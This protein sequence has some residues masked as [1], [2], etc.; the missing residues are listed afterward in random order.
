[1]SQHTTVQFRGEPVEIVYFD[2]GYEYDTNAHDIDWEFVE[3]PVDLN[4]TAAEEMAVL[5]QLYELVNQPH[6]YQDDF[7]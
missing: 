2:H 4:V 5:D 6:H 7:E 3:P 1:M